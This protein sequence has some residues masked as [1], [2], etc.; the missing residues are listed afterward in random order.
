MQNFEGQSFTLGCMHALEFK[1][2]TRDS[3]SLQLDNL[4]QQP[5]IYCVVSPHFSLPFAL[6]FSLYKQSP[7]PT[8]PSTTQQIHTRQKNPLTAEKYTILA[9]T[10]YLFA[11]I[12]KVICKFVATIITTYTVNTLTVPNTLKHSTKPTKVLLK[13]TTK[14]SCKHSVKHHFHMLSTY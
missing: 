3:W 11:S 7:S 2:R 13:I 6:P 10:S 14:Y 4:L 5:H 9:R 12:S 8:L 1:A